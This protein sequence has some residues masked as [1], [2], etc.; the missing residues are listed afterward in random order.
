[1]RVGTDIYR[2]IIKKMLSVHIASMER[3]M[4]ACQRCPPRCP[5]LPD[6]DLVKHPYTAPF[7]QQPFIP[8]TMLPSYIQLKLAK[9]E[10]TGKKLR[11]EEETKIREEFEEIEEK[12]RKTK[13][14]IAKAKQS[15]KDER[16]LLQARIDSLAGIRHLGDEVSALA[17]KAAEHADDEREGKVHEHEPSASDEEREEERLARITH[18]YQR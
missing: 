11:T 18:L 17:A 9:K 15:E 8:R 5:V 1:M 4:R 2:E 14:L 13:G 3:K 10:K 7:K 6:Q 12:I 16:V